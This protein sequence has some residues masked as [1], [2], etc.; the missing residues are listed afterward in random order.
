M[1]LPSSTSDIEPP[2]PAL[3]GWTMRPGAVSN[4]V[5]PFWERR[6]DGHAQVGLVCDARHENVNGKMHG[7]LLMMLADNGMGAAVRAT[8]EYPHFVTIQLDV[9]FMQGVDIGEF[10]TTECHV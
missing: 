1:T 6:V 5:G 7:G 3:D 8:G 2:N 4:L 10:V 9:A